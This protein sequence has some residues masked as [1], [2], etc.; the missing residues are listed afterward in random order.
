MALPS[1]TPEALAHSEA[2][3]ALI[4]R[5]IAAA[6]GWLPFSR[7]ME[8]ALYAPGMGYYSGGAHKFGRP[9]DFVTASEISP[10]FG[11]TLAAQVAEILTG[12]A[13]QL[14]EV[15]AGSGALAV[16]MLLEL[17]RLG[18]L[19][20]R[21][22]ILEVS[23]E[24]RERQSRRIAEE[25][26]HLAAR[27]SWLEA[28]PDSFIGLVLGN[29]VLDAMPVHVV[30]WDRN[31]V[32]ERGVILDA[33]GRFTWQDRPA[34]GSVLKAAS[35]LTVPTPFVS[36]INLAAGA[37]LAQWGRI[38]E[39][40]ALLL[41][42]YGFPRREYYHPQ[43]SAGTLVCHYRHHVHDDPFHLPG[44]NDITAH[45]DFT[46]VAEAAH[47][48][49]LAVLGYTSQ[50]EFLINCGLIDLLNAERDDPAAYL[51]LAAGAQKLISPSEMG[52]LFKAIALGKGLSQPL[53]G[54]RRG[55]RVH[56]L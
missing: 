29:E 53:L 16:Q 35:A 46:H 36:E 31:G 9:G 32:H 6:G 5:E 19:P 14:L 44:L 21:Y 30:A 24:L 40:G 1:A 34:F 28:L 20:E 27:V 47:G 2:L 17:E 48:A 49:G 51:R 22:W 55:D 3:A 54:F 50:A 43:R 11:R 8:L 12:S 56:A 37:W 18:C 7:Y 52:E 45:V 26:P 13:P 42:D 25:A 4:R 10:L 33:D 15:G 23:G 39:R 38:L 41:L